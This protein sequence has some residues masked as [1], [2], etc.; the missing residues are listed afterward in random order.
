MSIL[1][2][3]IQAHDLRV[4]PS[5][6]NDT[7]PSTAFHVT[8]H[9]V[10]SYLPLAIMLVSAWGC[11]RHGFSLR[12]LLD[13]R[14]APLSHSALPVLDR[15]GLQKQL[16]SYRGN[17]V[18]VDFWATWCP[19]CRAAF[20]HTVELGRKYAGQ[21][22]HLLTVSLDEASAVGDVV[23]FVALHNPAGNNFVSSHGSGRQSYSEFGITAQAIPCFRLYDR[24]G[25]LRHM[26][27]GESPELESRIQELL[28]EPIRQIEE[29]L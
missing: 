23:R 5:F 4:E 9:L 10:R 11:Q 20:P 28:A 26:F 12:G 22:F 25:T 3:A 2:A 27:T 24:H 14:K 6:M 13:D 17:V 8:E 7:R 19:P 15:V 29:A 18:L 21:G 16:D 1:S